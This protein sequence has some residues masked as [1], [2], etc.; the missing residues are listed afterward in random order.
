[1]DSQPVWAKR[2]ESYQGAG[3]PCWHASYSLVT[4]LDTCVRYEHRSRAWARLQY[5]REN[6]L[7]GSGCCLQHPYGARCPDWMMRGLYEERRM[8]LRGRIVVVHDRRSQDVEPGRLCQ[9]DWRHSGGDHSEYPMAESQI[10]HHP[11]RWNG[12]ARSVWS[13]PAALEEEVL[14]FLRL[15]GNYRGPDFASRNIAHCGVEIQ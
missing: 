6:R 11:F 3:S 12:N 4:I 15:S 1:M 7:Q 8:R 10:F 2:M 5:Q 9:E 14:A 13:L